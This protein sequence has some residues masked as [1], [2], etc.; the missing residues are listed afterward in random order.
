MLITIVDVVSCENPKCSQFAK[1]V[2][3]PR[4]L[5]TYYCQTCGSVNQIRGIDAGIAFSTEKY[6]KFLKQAGKTKVGS[7]KS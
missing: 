6:A 5:R 1:Q 2:D 4:E 7:D 3:L